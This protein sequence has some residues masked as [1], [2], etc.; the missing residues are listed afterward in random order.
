MNTLTI[1]QTASNI[2][3]RFLNIKLATC[4]SSSHVWR[5]DERYFESNDLGNDATVW[6][7]TVYI[8]YR[9][10]HTAFI[11]PDS[12]TRLHK[13][14]SPH[15]K[16]AFMCVTYDICFFNNIFH[17][18]H[19]VLGWESNDLLHV[20]LTHPSVVCVLLI[21]VVISVEEHKHDSCFLNNIFLSTCTV[22]WMSNDQRHGV[23][24]HPSV[25]YPNWWW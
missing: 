12:R 7:A 10:Y 11:G 1:S 18:I 23:V 4:R 22:Y 5:K 19:C 20:E 24:T 6:D 2:R 25:A 17:H 14:A 16:Y 9:G 3:T 15:D 13:L 21:G 8:T